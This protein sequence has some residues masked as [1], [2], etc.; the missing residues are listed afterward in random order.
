MADFEDKKVTRRSVLKGAALL[1]GVAAGPALLVSREA[2]AAKASKA[3]MMYQDHP[4]NGQDCSKCV[5]FIPGASASAMGTCKV[6]AGKISPK[7]YCI[8]FTPKS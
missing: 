1:A 8:A 3:A 2:Q 7:G 4:K 6:V 5:Q